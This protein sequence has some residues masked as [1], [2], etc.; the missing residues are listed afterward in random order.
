MKQTFTNSELFAIEILTRNEQDPV[1]EGINLKTRK[2][3]GM[4]LPVSVDQT[5]E[6][7]AKRIVEYMSE[8]GNCGISKEYLKVLART[9]KNFLKENGLKADEN[10][11]LTIANGKASEIY[12]WVKGSEEVTKIFQEWNNGTTPE[13]K[14]VQEVVK[15]TAEKVVITL[16]RAIDGKFGKKVLKPRIRVYWRFMTYGLL[17]LAFVKFILIPFFGWWD[18]VVRLLNALAWG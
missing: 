8:N 12:P 2:M 11:A 15:S 9:L 10:L 16:A 13:R 14:N 4:A 17:V 5:P 1:S 7:I 18:N 6:N 3:L